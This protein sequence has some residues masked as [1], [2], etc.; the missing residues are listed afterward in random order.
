MPDTD[1]LARAARN[2]RVIVAADTD[3]A[4]PLAASEATEPAVVFVSRADGSRRP[5]ASLRA[6]K[7]RRARD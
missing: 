6:P 4:D 1:I 2:G 3:F 7:H 5:P